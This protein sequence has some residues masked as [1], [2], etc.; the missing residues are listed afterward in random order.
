M[1]QPQATAE[2][3]YTAFRALKKSERE[4]FIN[5]LLEDET[6][7]NKLDV[8]SGVR[9]GVREVKDARRKNR[10]LQKLSD[11]IDENRS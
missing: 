9:A 4:A 11:F 8:F 2:V 1:T 7:Q 6:L 5:R 3:F 10:K